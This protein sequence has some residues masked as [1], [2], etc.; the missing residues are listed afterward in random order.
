M[1]NINKTFFVEVF[2]K[3]EDSI[4]EFYLGIGFYVDSTEIKNLLEICLINEKFVRI[5][6]NYKEDKNAEKND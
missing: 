1:E 2:D 6:I 3:E 4:S 5:S